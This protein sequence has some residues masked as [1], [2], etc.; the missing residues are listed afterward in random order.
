MPLLVSRC[1]TCQADMIPR[2][3]RRPTGRQAR[4]CD[5]LS[6][7]VVLPTSNAR[8]ADSA[9]VRQCVR[10]A[11]NLA[12]RRWAVLRASVWLNGK[13]CMR[14]S[15]VAEPLGQTYMRTTGRILFA[16]ARRN[17]L[18]C[19]TLLLCNRLCGAE[20]MLFH[21]HFLLPFERVSFRQQQ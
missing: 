18:G 13:R 11:I 19:S 16:V 5:R 15:Q 9:M 7:V 6:H 8:A 10:R 20:R 14:P 17:M 3:S 21:R 12:Y 2:A 1:V 4:R